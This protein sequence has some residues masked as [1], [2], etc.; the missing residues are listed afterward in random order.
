[1]NVP[2]AVTS[3]YEHSSSSASMQEKIVIME[4]PHLSCV[5]SLKFS[6]KV[7]KGEL[8]TVGE[9]IWKHVGVTVAPQP[10]NS[11][12]NLSMW[13]SACLCVCAHVCSRVCLKAAVNCSP[14]R[15]LS[16]QKGPSSPWHTFGER[17]VLVERMSVIC[18]EAYLSPGVW[19]VCCVCA[20]VHIIGRM[21]V[22]WWGEIKVFVLDFPFTSDW[23]SP[24][25]RG[26]LRTLCS[27]CEVSLLYTH[28]YCTDT[29][30]VFVRVC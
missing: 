16:S 7:S 14:S 13:D 26:R 5:S 6:L 29:V 27:V 28:P 17:S 12:C 9:F 25:G 23:V 3:N 8:W 18:G 24:S 4:K 11:C 21:C 2:R 22:W 19:G 10:V 20:Y 1:M 30:C 15:T